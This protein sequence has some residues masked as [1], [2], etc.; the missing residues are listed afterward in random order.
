[1]PHAISVS[2]M[3]EAQSGPADPLWHLA[4]GE[5]L[6]LDIGPG[7][8]R[9]EVTAGRV[10]ITLDGDVAAGDLW[11]DAGEGVDLPHGARLVADAHPAAAFRLVVPPVACRQQRQRR[12]LSAGSAVG[13]VGAVWWTRA[14]RWLS[15]TLAPAL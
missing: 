13:G 10:W 14:R 15:A 12:G 2:L 7:P 8:R 6:R 9:L 1:M 11:L 5:A 3:P 4:A